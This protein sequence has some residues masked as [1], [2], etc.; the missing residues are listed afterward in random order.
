MTGPKDY[1]PWIPF[2]RVYDT[3][4]YGG[5]DRLS[6]NR[7]RDETIAVVLSTSMGHSGEPSTA[8]AEAAR[9]LSERRLEEARLSWEAS[10][11]GSRRIRVECL[12][13][14]LGARSTKSPRSWK[15]CMC[16][17]LR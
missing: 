17:S 9:G 14:E 4:C 15:I 3:P 2:R 5:V 7:V 12:S 11:R 10:A 16:F 6:F 1:Q 13:N 8:E